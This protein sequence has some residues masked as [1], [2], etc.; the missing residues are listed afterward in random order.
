MQKRIFSILATAILFSTLLP[1]MNAQTPIEDWTNVSDLSENEYVFIRLKTGKKH[2]G[3][4]LTVSDDSIEILNKKNKSITLERTSI[5]TVHIGKW[6]D[7]DKSR[8]RG[9][10]LGMIGGIVSYGVLVAAAGKEWDL[11][12]PGLLVIGGGVG[13]LL[14]KRRANKPKKGELIYSAR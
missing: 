14:G 4:L 13:G 1:P 7:S 9:A 2:K 6:R 3:Q 11:S 5:R 8:N 12:A 10:G